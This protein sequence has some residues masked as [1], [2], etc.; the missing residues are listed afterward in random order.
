MARGKD[1]GAIARALA[2]MAQVLAQ[3]NEQAAIGRRNEGEAEERRL[4]RFLRNNPP[5]FKGRFDPEG[6]QTWVQRMERI[7]RAM[8]TSD[9]QK[10]RLA[11]HM[12]AEEAEFWWT[13][14]KGRLETGGEVVTWARFKTEFLRKYF[15]EDLRTRKEVEFLNL[16]QGSLSVA[17]YAAKFEEL[18]RFCPYAEGAMVSKCVKF[19]SGL[20]LEIYQ[21]MCVQEIRDFDTGAT[22]SFISASC[23]ERLNLVVTPLLRGMVVDTPASGSVTTSLVCAKCPVNFGNVDFELDLVCLPLK[24]MD[25]IFGMDWMLSF[26]VS[27]NC[28][29]KS[30][31]FSKPVDELGGKFLTAEQVKKSLGSEACV[32]MMFASL[33][34]SSEKGIG[35][36]PVVQ[37]FPEVFPD[38]ITELPPEREV[39]FTI[40]LIPGT[41]PISIAPYR[42]STSE[43]GELKKQLEELLEKQFIRPSVSPWGAPVLLV[44][45]KD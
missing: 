6:A 28:L 25:V 30:I 3:S 43:L 14:V 23:V 29:T 13:N 12:L 9:D 38:N 42:M 33:K 18:S 16:K 7:F 21:Y 10:V 2:A 15:P 31:T 39:E 34:E 19:E 5:T 17:E 27:I 24:H 36:L 20:R 1:D 44:K 45:K 8:V 26:G 35:D 11:T 37:E 32:F 4:D 41:S 22:H 40:D